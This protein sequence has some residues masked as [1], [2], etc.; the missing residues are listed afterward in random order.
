M[1][2]QHAASEQPATQGERHA[3]AEASRVLFIDDDQEMGRLV[4]KQLERGGLRARVAT[5]KAEALQEL[6]RRDFDVVVCD[7]QLGA[8]NGLDICKWVGEN[9]PSTPV[10]MITAFGNMET[11]V[12][13]IR[14]GAHDFVAK[15]IDAELLAHTVRRAA[16]HSEL[17]RELARLREDAGME[18]SLGGLIGQSAPMRELAEVISRVAN[19]EASVL[20]SGESGTGKELVARALHLRSPRRSGPFVAINCAALPPNLLESELFGHVR[21]AFTDAKVA[22]EGLMREANGGTLFLDELGEMPLEM[23]VKLLRALQERKVRPV[24]GTKELE[25]DTRVVAATNRDI[26]DD[27]KRGTFREDLYYRINVIRLRPPPLRERGNDILLLADYV[28]RRV[29]ERSGRKVTGFAPAVASKLLEYDWPGN[30]REL[31]N[32][33]ERAVAMAR[34][35][36]ITV[37]DLPEK[38]RTHR[39]D[40]VSLG[41]DSP[42]EMLP[43][44]ALEERYIRR[45]LSVV[46]GNKTQ[47][48]KILGL[49]RRTLYR[50]LDRYEARDS[51]ERKAHAQSSQG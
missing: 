9:R 50:K 22:R 35:D 46:Q 36:Q 7:V 34:F 15:P 4:H 24:G 28:L 43:L 37:D 47:A 42:E 27:V 31:E 39:S 45:V 38:V 32:V 1:S 30:V 23:Q 26:E 16:K 18:S 10:V 51:A 25:F 21:G 17:H 5:T 14:A 13:A 44:D 48:A 41:G 6:Q 19:S 3:E 40:Q 12:A 33:V 2:E 49:D 8:D 11:A 20:I 29:A